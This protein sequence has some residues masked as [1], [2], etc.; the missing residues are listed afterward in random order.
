MIFHQ[1]Q[2]TRILSA[3]LLLA[4]FFLGFES[5]AQSTEFLIKKHNST[6]IGRFRVGD[7]IKV[8][9]IDYTIKG[10]IDGIFEEAMFINGK[11][12]EYD[13]IEKVTYYKPQML[14][15]SQ[16]FIA[17]GLLLA[18]IVSFNSLINN[19]RPLL[20]QTFAI[21]S[22]SAVVLGTTLFKFGI[23]E[24]K[25]NDK[26]YFEVMDFSNLAEPKPE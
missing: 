20:D 10:A 26:R 16:K 7:P 22:G 2:G 12:I 25:M 18:G 4:F 1:I 24:Y 17:A 23:V 21:I 13:R 6:K 14:Y 15:T 3:I 5:A 9:T 11:E 8:K 19:E